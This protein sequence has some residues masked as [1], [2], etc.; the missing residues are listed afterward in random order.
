[1]GLSN[2]GFLEV[3]KLLDA[4]G[5]EMQDDVASRDET[6]RRITTKSLH[7]H[8]V[9]ARYPSAK[10]VEKVHASG[11]SK[12]RMYDHTQLWK[13]LNAKDEGSGYGCRGTRGKWLWF[14]KW[15]DEVLEHCAAAGETYREKKQSLMVT[16]NKQ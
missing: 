2:R 7:A 5:L 3:D 13:Q 16:S 1:M 4:L 8:A 6:I 12:F 11:F 14:Q 15:V 10:V 9:L